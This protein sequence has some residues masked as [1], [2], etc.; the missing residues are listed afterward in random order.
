MPLNSPS[1]GKHYYG[2]RGSEYFA[3]QSNIG[4]VGAQLD[5]WKF[6]DRTSTDLVVVDFGCGS[7]DLLAALPAGRRIGI[8]PNDDARDAAAAKGLDVVRS[9]AELPGELA[10][11]VISH[12]ALEH[13]L[14]PL[15]E[16]QAL[17][18]ILKP[19]GKLILWLPIDDWRR[20]RDSQDRSFSEDLNHHLYTWTPLNLF[21]LL[22]EAGFEPERV[23]TVSHAWPKGFRFYYRWMPT[24]IFDLIA[25]IT[26]ILTRQHQVVAI[27]R[28]GPVSEPASL[29]H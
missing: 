25:R 4:A 7:G 28:P 1:V 9:S 13:T 29:A 24:P 10:D 27:A 6:I 16:L 3:W 12:H 21:N 2:T 23:R 19:S 15:K 11:V 5:R 8:E 18:G 20:H 26:P 17:R 22:Q 14:H